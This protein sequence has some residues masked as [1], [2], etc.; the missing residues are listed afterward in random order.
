MEKNGVFI[1]EKKCWTAPTLEGNVFLLQKQKPFEEPLE[2]RKLYIKVW[3]VLIL[4]RF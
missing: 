3:T 4:K 2:D 1:N